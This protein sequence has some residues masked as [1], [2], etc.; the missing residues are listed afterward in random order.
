MLYRVAEGILIPSQISFDHLCRLEDVKSIFITEAGFC[1]LITKLSQVF[2]YDRTIC[3][4]ELLSANNLAAQSIIATASNSFPNDLDI[5]A[6]IEE[7]AF[8]NLSA[9]IQQSAE[10]SSLSLTHAEARMN[11][12]IYLDSAAEYRRSLRQYVLSAIECD[13]Q[14]QIDDLCQELYGP[15]SMTHHKSGDWSP[16]LLGISKYE[17]L[18]DILGILRGTQHFQELFKTWEIL[19]QAARRGAM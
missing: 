11:A 14:S 10:Q 19:S 6:S 13:A 7:E 17:L 1:I 12:C 2:A 9:L 3:W 15:V 16:T 5:V 4:T 18:Q 8:H